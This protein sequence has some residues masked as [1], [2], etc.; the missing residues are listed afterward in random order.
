M[1]FTI[2]SIVH[3]NFTIEHIKEKLKMTIF[4]EL[5]L[6]T[7]SDY[8]VQTAP[9]RHADSETSC[10]ESKR[11]FFG[12]AIAVGLST[13][14]PLTIFAHP[15]ADQPAA[16]HMKPW[17]PLDLAAIEPKRSAPSQAP[18][19]DTVFWSG[20]SPTMRLMH[21]T[22]TGLGLIVKYQQNP[23]RGSRMLAYLHV[24]MHDAWHY[25]GRAASPVLGS[26]EATKHAEKA[27]HEAASQILAH[28]YP[29][30]TPGTFSAMLAAMKASLAFNSD[31]ANGTS[32]SANVS[33]ALIERS[34][35]DGA[36]RVWPI[37]LRPADFPGIWQATYPLYAVNPT[38][39]FADSWRP[40][41]KPSS[42]RYNPPTAPRPGS[43]QHQQETAE[44]LTTARNLSAEHKQLAEKWNLDAGS[45]TP[46]GVWVG[47][48]LDQ[49]NA[50]QG[51]TPASLTSSYHQAAK[52]LSVLSTLCVTMQD[53]F[54][55]C[56]AI[57]FRDWSERPIT[58]IRRTLDPQ[59]A[60]VLITPGFPGYVSG[61][62]SV[63]GAAAAALIKFWPEQ[64]ERFLAMA[65]E[66]ADSRLWGGIHF[67]SDN[68]EGLKL[69]AA[70]GADVLAHIES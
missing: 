27:A 64:K 13:L 63:S 11:C 30:E 16:L 53:S 51:E 56:W 1:L 22:R 40:W 36:G 2:Q 54:I 47:L 14:T 48:A 68:E 61:H 37:K 6:R 43:P 66:A 12:K 17:M 35:R 25:A 69:G 49:L 4:R 24:G 21:W 46:A 62:S 45:V 39:G 19:R 42:T 70:V 59:F 23:L 7:N 65:Q 5:I 57:K 50:S 44:V 34:L 67:R 9:L 8:S 20:S 60:S 15:K 28:F 58:A 33:A 31:Y 3:V 18:S 32:I 52:F 55:A 41:V 38:E 10:V 29:N 26:I